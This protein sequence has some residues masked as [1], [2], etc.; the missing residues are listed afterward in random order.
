M[1]GPELLL[2]LHRIGADAEAASTEGL[3]LGT[4][5]AEV[6]ALLGASP[7]H[8]LGVEEQRDRALVQL[9]VEADGLAVV[10]HELEVGY[11]VTGAHSR[12]L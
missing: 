4:E 1:L 2:S 9:L 11:L 7:R 12:A 3:E 10:G 6:A 5:V 8:G